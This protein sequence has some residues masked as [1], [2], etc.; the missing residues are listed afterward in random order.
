MEKVIKK[1]SPKHPFEYHFFDEIFERSYRTEQKSGK[2]YGVFAFLSIIIACLGL[3]GLA[4][5]AAAQRTKEVG[6]RKSL[7][8]S[9]AN[10]TLLFLKEFV[11]WVFFAN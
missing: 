10:I 1:F 6:I 9:T 7:G 11:K 4:S 5:F 2:L 3:L 8:A